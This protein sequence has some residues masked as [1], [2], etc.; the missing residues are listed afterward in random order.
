MLDAAVFSLAPIARP[1]RYSAIARRCASVSPVA[2]GAIDPVVSAIRIFSGETLRTASRLGARL[3]GDGVPTWHV[4]HR[5]WTSAI[6]EPGWANASVGVATAAAIPS[7]AHMD[8][9]FTW[10]QS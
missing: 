5:S 6:G 8:N 3:S 9:N 10:H 2:F 7:R 4:T 1:P